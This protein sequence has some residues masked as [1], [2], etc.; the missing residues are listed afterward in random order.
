MAEGPQYPLYFFLIDLVIMQLHIRCAG[1]LGRNCKG[2]HGS[3]VI[4]PYD[5]FAMLSPLK[6]VLLEKKG[7]SPRSSQCNEGCTLLEARISLN[8]CM[9]TQY[10][11]KVLRNDCH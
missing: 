8:P 3:I 4:L 2:K 9:F 6:P 10:L 7:S 5:S 11:E 1:Y